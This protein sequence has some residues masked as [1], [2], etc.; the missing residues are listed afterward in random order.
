MVARLGD[1][2]V[3]WGRLV[4][5]HEQEVLCVNTPAPL[6]RLSPLSMTYARTL[7]SRIPCMDRRPS[8]C[9]CN[10]HARPPAFP[11]PQ[12]NDLLFSYRHQR[13]HAP[14]DASHGFFALHPYPLPCLPPRPMTRAPT[15]ASKT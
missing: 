10:P 5:K 13:S 1:G 12:A 8:A 9:Y 4:V 6:P 3:P 2:G 7:V 11:T 14:L 15:T